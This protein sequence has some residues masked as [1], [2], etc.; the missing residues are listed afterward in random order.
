VEFLSSEKEELLRFLKHLREIFME[1]ISKIDPSSNQL[2]FRGLN[3]ADL[4]QNYSFEAVVFLLINGQLPDTSELSDTAQ[5]LVELRRYYSKDVVSLA[6]LAR[7]LNQLQ[8][9]HHLSNKDALFSFLSLSPLV[10]ANE[11][12]SKFTHR[13]EQ[14]R[15]DL[16]QA[17]NFLWMTKC[18]M[19]SEDDINDFQT[20]LVLHMDDPSNPSLTALD[21]SMRDGKSIADALIAAH[22]VH[23]GPLHHGAGTEAMR[24]LFEMRNSDNSVEYLRNR[25]YSG[26]K[27][28]GLGHRIYR[29]VDPRA[30]ILEETLQRRTK[31]TPNEWIPHIIDQVKLEGQ[32]LLKEEK[33]VEAYP[34]VD[35][36]N[37]AVYFSLGFPF[38][39]NT[40][41]FAVARA[42]GWIAH[43][44]EWLK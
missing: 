15:T 38:E 6:D 40:E 5:R 21:E 17:A 29:G 16:G 27:I 34:N 43:I 20:S 42:A 12:Y 4:C 28:F 44:M 8:K 35:L 1:P 31:N 24:M 14:P 26:G 19:P 22:T 13:I 36:Y 23:L 2:F 33:G 37:A 10:A 3:V 11:L 41:L 25:L 30:R 7:S 18:T 9:K 32:L 39:L